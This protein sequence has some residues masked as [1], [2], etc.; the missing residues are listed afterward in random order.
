VS[1]FATVLGAVSVTDLNSSA[2]PALAFSTSR[3]IRASTTGIS[4]TQ[5]TR[6]SPRFGSTTAH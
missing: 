2:R 4:W 6:R 5:R 3:R 1:V